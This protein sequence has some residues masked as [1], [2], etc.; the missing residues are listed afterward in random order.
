[1][2]QSEAPDEVARVDTA[3]NRVLEREREA[4]AA[5]AEC[6][7]RADALVAEA[8]RK[9]QRIEARGEERVTAIHAI[10]D[11]SVAQ[12]IR[13]LLGQQPPV[14]QELSPEQMRHLDAAIDG[15]ADE[16]WMGRR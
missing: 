11:R 3:I 15:L 13:A 1:M 16:I 12:A 14:P 7:E 8:R 2:K 5:I 6:Q 9:A 10:C 4:R